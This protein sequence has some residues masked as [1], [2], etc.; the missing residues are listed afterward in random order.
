[1]AG[2]RD[3]MARDIIND[4]DVRVIGYV[5][6]DT[7]HLVIAD[8]CY[9]SDVQ[10]DAGNTVGTE[11]LRPLPHLSD[12]TGTAGLGIQVETGW[13]DGVYPVIAE[14]KHGR[15]AGVYIEFIPDESDG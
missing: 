10:D 8:P 3:Y 1:V 4:T 7:G 14:Y 12:D 2:D 6:V 13:G 5:G 11:V 9:M 15:V